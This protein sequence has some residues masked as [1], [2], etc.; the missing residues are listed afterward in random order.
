MI[1]EIVVEIVE[2]LGETI[3]R[4]ITVTT[5]L[6]PRL[7]SII[8]DATQIH[9]VL[10]NL[11]LNARDAMLPKGGTL[12]IATELVPIE[13]VR[14]HFPK[15]GAMGYVLLSVADTGVGMDEA[16]RARVFEPFFTTKEPGKG[17]G[18]GLATVYGIVEGHGGFVDVASEPGRGT[19]F[20][21]YLPVPEISVAPSP[22]TTNA[23]AEVRGGN[24]TILI[25]EDETAMA[26]LL[27]EALIQKGYQVLTAQDGLHGLEIFSARKDEIALVLTDMG[28]PKLGGNMLLDRLLELKR[29]TRVV[30]ASG[31]L[32]QSQRGELLRAGAKAFISKPYSLIHVLRV[33]RDVLDGSAP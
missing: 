9:Q 30:I 25:V 6:T 3:P 21:L 1:N 2:L 7:P 29:D 12:S 10:L 13:A 24:E 11:C 8:A 26:E 18:L 14:S 28:L 33:L 19:T 22:E 20:S 17:T 16:T 4:I 15:A 5:D 23:E 31:Y 32:E 27:E